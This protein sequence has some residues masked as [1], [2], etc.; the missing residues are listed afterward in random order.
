M[1]LDLLRGTRS[2]PQAVLIDKACGRLNV[3]ILAVNKWPAARSG[4]RQIRAVFVYRLLV[5]RVDSCRVS[6]RRSAG[7]A[8]CA[9]AIAMM[10]AFFQAFVLNDLFTLSRALMMGWIG[11]AFFVCH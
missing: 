8:I 6:R 3:L 2:P 10:T 5:F 11:R 7:R 4:G 1:R 9:C